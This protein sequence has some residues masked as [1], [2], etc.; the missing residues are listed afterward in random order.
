M[1]C[2]YKWLSIG[3]AATM[4]FSMTA[5]KEEE[6]PAVDIGMDPPVIAPVD[7]TSA[8]TTTTVAPAPLFQVNAVTGVEDMSGSLS[9]PVG[10]MVA[11]ND[12]IQSEQ[13]GIGSADMWVEAETEG[14]ITRLMAVF[15]SSERV[16]EA[17]GPVRS[18][19]TPFAKI[20][21]ALGLGYA[22]AGGSYTALD[23]IAS[24]DIADMDVNGGE[25][26]G[27]YSWRDHSF[28]HDYEY[29]LRTNG[30]YLTK[31]LTD[32]DYSTTPTREIPWTFGAQTGETAT[33]VSI[34][35]SG[36]QRIGFTYDSA[37]KTYT[38]TNGYSESVHTDASG[39]AITPNTVLV[40]YTDKYWENDTTIDFYLQS[41]EGYVFSDGKMR[42][43][44]WT[45]SEGGFTM[46]EKDGSKLTIA[47]GKVYL[48]V[49]ASGY[50]SDI[51][52]N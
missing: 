5:C 37:K 39:A 16:P 17:I 33:K 26:G 24:S 28:P 23:Y 27:E 43:F 21:Q 40:L 19:R 20:A 49:A 11:N 38:K 48:C 31:Y 8:P 15:A 10:V 4:L 3:L 29:R 34:T 1:N 42:R 36:A 13:V 41:G 46:T 51:S 47:Q 6:P 22:H 50:S 25:N 52:Y 35:M 12:F 2:V 7:S 45:R 14:G 18:A 30:E 44:D 32:R 9:R